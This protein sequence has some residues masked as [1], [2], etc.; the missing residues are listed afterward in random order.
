MDSHANSA[1]TVQLRKYV[2]IEPVYRA[3][4]YSIICAIFPISFSGTLEPI[5]M[6]KL[7]LSPNSPTESH[8]LPGFRPGAQDMLL[9]SVTGR[10]SALIS[11]PY[12][13][14]H[15]KAS[16]RPYNRATTTSSG[17]RVGTIRSCK[18][19]TFRHIEANS[20]ANYY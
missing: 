2:F 13:K 16:P 5:A 6:P 3:C 4:I 9:S 17:P 7:V 14:K 12:D 8:P 1:D 15:P 19:Q 11:L 10:N 18:P 20:K